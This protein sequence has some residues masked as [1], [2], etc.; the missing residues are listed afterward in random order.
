MTEAGINSELFTSHSCRFASTSK[1]TE[2]NMSISNNLKVSKLVWRFDIQKALATLERYK[3]NNHQLKKIFFLK[4]L[5]Q[6]DS[7]KNV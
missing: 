3:K 1:A 6:W 5:E 4:L 7:R 2:A